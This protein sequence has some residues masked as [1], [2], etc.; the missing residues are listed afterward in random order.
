MTPLA[1]LPKRSDDSV[2]CASCMLGEQHTSSVVLALPPSESWHMRRVY[3]LQCQL[4]APGQAKILC[5][6]PYC[7]D[8]MQKSHVQP[9]LNFQRAWSTRVSLESR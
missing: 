8:V 7:T 4:S 1:R 3:F 5:M 2:S 6:Q 9:S